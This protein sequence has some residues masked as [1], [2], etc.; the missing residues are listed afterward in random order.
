MQTLKEFKAEHGIEK[1]SF[2]KSHSSSRFV[3]SFGNDKLI[4]T[5]EEYDPKK[6]GYIYD[7]PAA[8]AGASWILS[9]KQPKEADFT[10]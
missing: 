3:A 6:A 2:Y 4:I 9:N 7:N 1:L 8:E 10:L 5:T